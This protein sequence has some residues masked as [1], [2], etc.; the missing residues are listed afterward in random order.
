MKTNMQK[1]LLLLAAFTVII[2]CSSRT[3]S[4]SKMMSDEMSYEAEM[5]MEAD[6][7]PVM[8]SEAGGMAETSPGAT[9]PQEQPRKRIYN[10]SAGLVV[11]DLKETRRKLEQLA[12]DSGGYI[13]SSYTDYLVLRVPASKFNVLFD[14][15]LLMGRV[16]YQQIDT[17]DVT[18]QYSDTSARLETAEKTRKRLYVLL[19]SST[20]AEE[21][22]KILREIGRLTEEIESI[23]QQLQILDSRIAFS[24]I[25]VE[26]VSRLADEG[27]RAEI[28][29]PWIESLS[30]VYPL[31][32]SL[33]AKISLNVG[34]DFAVF[35]KESVFIAE[36][37]RGTSIT[38]SSA[39]NS[40]RGDAAFW[41]KAL[42][43]H[44]SD[45]YAEAVSRNMAFGD[46]E[47][48]GVEFVSKDRKAFRY[49]AGVV[50]SGRYLHIIEIFSPD[51]KTDFSVL[52]DLFKEGE[53]R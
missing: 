4:Y 20:D 22:A 26:L 13:E 39:R 33:K 53:C 24:R 7:A 8:K 41:Q 11:E 18:D 40:P 32:D 50:A 17:W 34:D 6:A 51:M 49:F 5:P 35:D 15:V 10:G 1:L 38:V 48:A 19:E 12:E 43:F 23:R 14:S 9:V 45:Y 25:T 28:P 47:M 16:R 31:S 46:K 52:Y 36:D 37:A 21:R 27:S 3:E 30:P 42:L 44:L 29:F 2:S